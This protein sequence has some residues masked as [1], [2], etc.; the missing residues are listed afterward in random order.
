[1]G[2]ENS[3]INSYRDLVA[4]EKAR[5]LVKAVYQ[6][7]APFPREETYG[8]TQ[9][10]RRAAVSV[11]SNIAEGYGRGSRKEYV[12]FLQI[13]RGSLYEVE[14]QLVLSGDLGYLPDREIGVLVEQVNECARILH[15]LIKS[16]S[17]RSADGA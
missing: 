14:T 8:L 2:T 13:A 3:K 10:L 1:M 4:W 15:G 7:T 16:L 9:Q 11:P 17:A 12:R 6:A 5:L